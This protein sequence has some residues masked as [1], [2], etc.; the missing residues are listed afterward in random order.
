MIAEDF[1]KWR[2]A[3]D[4]M[5]FE[6]MAAWY[7]KAHAEHPV[8]R[9]FNLEAVERWLE[10]VSQLSP[11]TVVELGGY[12]GE[13]AGLCLELYS[14][15]LTRWTNLEIGNVVP[16]CESP[17]YDHYQLL[18]FPWE[19]N[20]VVP[21]DGFLCSHSLEHLSDAHAELMLKTVNCRHVYIDMPEGDWNG[22]TAA[23]KL[24]MGWAGVDRLLV[25]RGFKMDWSMPTEGEAR[26]YSR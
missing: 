24:T 1:D 21:G 15:S 7:D 6:E 11:F 10:S 22:A 14:I 4:T 18:G 20:L 8:Q 19:I 23:H 13:L 25:E 5:T 17:R 12:D 16:V 3:Y 9:H 2:A 26:S